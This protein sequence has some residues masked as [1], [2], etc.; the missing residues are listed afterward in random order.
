M[1]APEWQSCRICG[2][3]GYETC[4]DCLTVRSARLICPPI[5]QKTDPAKLHAD[6]KALLDYPYSPM[7]LIIVGDSGTQKTRTAWLIVNRWIAAGKRVACFDSLSFA[8]AVDRQFG[9]GDGPE[10]IEEVCS[11]DAVYFDDIDKCKLTEK[12]Q[13]EMFGIIDKFVS[14]EKPII[15]TS[16]TSGPAFE[17]R[18]SPNI[19]PAMRRRLREFCKQAVFRRSDG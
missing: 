5:F 15:V 2:A 11:H 19:G 6:A 18:F 7:G 8:H 9:N 1:S 16:N 3:A 17:Q 12:V 14:N 4:P 10:W 13:T